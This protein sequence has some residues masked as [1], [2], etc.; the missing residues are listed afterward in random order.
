M[1]LLLVMLCMLCMVMPVESRAAYYTPVAAKVVSSTPATGQ[2]GSF[3]ERGNKYAH[4]HRFRGTRHSFL[5]VLAFTFS[6]I[7]SVAV[8]VAL[9][10]AIAA[11]PT[12]P[13]VLAVY[14]ADLLGIVLGIISFN[15]TAGSDAVLLAL[16]NLLAL[17]LGGAIYQATKGNY[18]PLLKLLRIFTKH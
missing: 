1:K 6:C 4:M 15:D 12:A 17:F 5:G 7:G 10:A 16:A 3:H 14:A 11:V 9:V 13:F 8:V 2:A 18:L